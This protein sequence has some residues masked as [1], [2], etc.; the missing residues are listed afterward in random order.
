MRLK[1]ANLSTQSLQQKNQNLGYF[2]TANKLLTAEMQGN[3]Y[4]GQ[5]D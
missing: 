2:S 4:V 3:R 5:R 1:L